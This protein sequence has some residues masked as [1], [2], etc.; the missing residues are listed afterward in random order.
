MSDIP[1]EI[2][3]EFLSR[4]PAQPLLRLRCVSKSWREIIDSPDFI[5]LHLNRALQTNSDRKLILR[6]TFV[7]V[8]DFDELEQ[9]NTAVYTALDLPY[10]RSAFGTDILGSCHGL[11]C[12]DTTGDEDRMV[13]WNPTTHKYHRFPFPE[14]ENLGE[15]AICIW[16]LVFGFGYDKVSDDY[17]VLRIFQSHE[18]QSEAKVYSLKLNSWRKIPCFPYCLKYKRANGVLVAGALHWAV[19][20]T[21]QLYMENLIGAF[22]LGTEEYRLVPEPNYSEGALY[23]TVGVLGESLCVVCNYYD[24]SYVDIWVMKSYGVKESWTKLFTVTESDLS[25]KPLEF[26]T[27]LAFSKSGREVFTVVNG[28][29]PLWYD[30]EQRKIRDSAFR[31]DSVPAIM[32]HQMCFGSLVRIDGGVGRVVDVTEGEGSGGSNGR[33]HKKRDEF[34]SEGFRLIL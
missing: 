22:D 29:Q 2:V 5:K 27:P 9:T 1:R 28:K 18:C 26:V 15:S 8:A 24:S 30:I 16:C 10:K 25:G 20:R 17:K 33:N 7:Y 34:L 13:L 11:L 23:V 32:V 31:I 12:L 4:V 14:F 6:S 3:A 19:C 21:P